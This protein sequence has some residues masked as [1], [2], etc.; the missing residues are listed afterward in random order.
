[1][2]DSLEEKSQNHSV[3][4]NVESAVESLV[5]GGAEG[6]ADFLIK[7]PSEAGE[8]CLLMVE[9]YQPDDRYTPAAQ[10]SFVIGEL[11]KRLEPKEKTP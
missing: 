10:L 5:S 1:M 8:F 7:H 11:I 9:K 6:A 3:P 4:E 2:P